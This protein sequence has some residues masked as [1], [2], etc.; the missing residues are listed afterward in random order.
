MARA[1]SVVRPSGKSLAFPRKSQARHTQEEA[2]ERDPNL[3]ET[4]IRVLGNMPWGTHVC[5]FYQTEQDLLDT[6]VSFFE[7]GLK[8][9]EL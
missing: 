5:V 4:G 7:A 2:L 3:R 6:A 1:P 8:N 9:N